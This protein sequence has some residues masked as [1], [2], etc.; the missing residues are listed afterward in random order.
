[1]KWDWMKNGLY[2][3]LTEGMDKTGTDEM[4]FLF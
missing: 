2:E 4:D 3:I 1:M